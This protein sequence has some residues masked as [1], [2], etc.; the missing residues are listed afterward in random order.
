MNVPRLLLARFQAAE[1]DATAAFRYALSPSAARL[2]QLNGASPAAPAHKK[3]ELAICSGFGSGG[4]ESLES[5]GSSL[6]LPNSMLKKRVWP[7]GARLLCRRSS[8]L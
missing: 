8:L 4:R 1:D 2:F 5:A 7:G 3:V 6:L